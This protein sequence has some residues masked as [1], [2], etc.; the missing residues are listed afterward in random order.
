MVWHRKV[1]LMKVERCSGELTLQTNQVGVTFL[2]EQEGGG[3]RNGPSGANVRPLEGNGNR[4]PG[5]REVPLH[6]P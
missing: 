1:A 3:K 5:R 6:H 4:F 2:S